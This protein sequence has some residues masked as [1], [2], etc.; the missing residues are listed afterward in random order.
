MAKSKEQQQE[1]REALR[2]KK[3]A[4]ARGDRVN[5]DG[6]GEDLRVLSVKPSLVSGWHVEVTAEDG[7][8]WNVPAE[9]V[10]N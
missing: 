8:T 2:A 9:R 6:I 3:P 7:R 1:E 5:A 10:W 4:F